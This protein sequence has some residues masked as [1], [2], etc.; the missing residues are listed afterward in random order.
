MRS[1]AT[2]ALILLLA[3]CSGGGESVMLANEAEDAGS[4]VAEVFDN[5]GAAMPNGGADAEPAEINSTI[6]TTT[7]APPNASPGAV[8]LSKEQVEAQYTPAFKACMES[9]DAAKGVTVAMADCV[10]AEL[11]I[12]DER[13]NGAYKSAMGKRDAAGQAV[14]RDEER[15]WIKTRDATCDALAAGGSIDAIV[16]PNC[17]LDETIRR[18]AALQPMAG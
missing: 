2:I 16:I 9:G 10:A 4:G 18:R 6:G 11:K 15:A 14:L 8:S 13:L 5:S 17:V 3:A 7:P 1:A 12:Q